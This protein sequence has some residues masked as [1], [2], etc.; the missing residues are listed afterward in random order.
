MTKSKQPRVQYVRAL[1]SIDNL[2]LYLVATIESVTVVEHNK[3]RADVVICFAP[4]A[5]YRTDPTTGQRFIGRQVVTRPL[6]IELDNEPFMLDML[7]E[8]LAKWCNSGAKVRLMY[9]RDLILATLRVMGD[10][11]VPIPA[12]SVVNSLMGEPE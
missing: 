12:A 9:R 8:P 11:D 1:D 4:G 3:R 2:D 7:T 5:G 10:E 6:V